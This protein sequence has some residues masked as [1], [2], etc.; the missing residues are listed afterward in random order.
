MQ[1]AL[2]V[3]ANAAVVSCQRVRLA[4]FEVAD[5]RSRVLAQLVDGD[6]LPAI[7]FGVREVTRCWS[8]VVGR[9]GTTASARVRR[10][11]RGMGRLRVGMWPVGGPVIPGPAVGRCCR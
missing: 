9:V 1:K 5:N 3:G 11:V 10:W 6:R 8:V 2:M 7:V 4:T